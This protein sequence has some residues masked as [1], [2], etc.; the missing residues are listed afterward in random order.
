[1][2]AS[3]ST[4]YC[5]SEPSENDPPSSPPF[6]RSFTSSSGPS[7]VKAGAHGYDSRT[8]SRR[9][10]DDAPRGRRGCNSTAFRI[11]ALLTLMLLA[12]CLHLGTDLS[13]TA[14]SSTKPASVLSNPGF[15]SDNNHSAR[16]SPSHSQGKRP[17]AALISL[18][19]NA[20][21]EGILQSMRQLEYRWNRRY[22]YPWMFFTEERSGFSEA[23]KNA[24]S[25][26]T[27]SS[28]HYH[29]IPPEHWSTPEWVDGSLHRDSLGYLEG[30]GV[31]KAGMLSY[32]H[33]CRWNSGFFYLHEALEGLE[34]YWRVE[35]DVHFLCD[36]EE[37]LFEAMRRRGWKY[38]FNMGIL[39]DG[40]GFVGLWKA[41]VDFAR[42][43][44]E[45][46]HPDADW[47][48]LVDTPPPEHPNDGS[49]TSTGTYNAC[50]FFSNFELGSLEFFRSDAYQAFFHHLD[51]TGGFF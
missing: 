11:I 39:D 22:G 51:Q 26:I 18:V 49:D 37:D 30:L 34:R 38:A 29:T 47:S 28:T 44:P 50:Q 33:M 23:F 13:T 41:T 25:A 19:R 4:I 3:S 1:M 10:D 5:A 17:K 45:H 36:V 7:P 32:R 35:P 8:R 2:D 46:I 21:L 6:A 40:R 9:R 48:W 16:L 15:R 20:D 14:A 27:S 42:R 31:G 43:H 24:T 12:I